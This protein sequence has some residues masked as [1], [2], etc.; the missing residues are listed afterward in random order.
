MGTCIDMEKYRVDTQR[1]VDKLIVYID[2]LDRVDS[3]TNR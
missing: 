3:G 2:R 1:Q